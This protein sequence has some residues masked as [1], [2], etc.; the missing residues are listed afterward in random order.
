VSAATISEISSYQYVFDMQLSHDDSVSWM[1]MGLDPLSDMF[2][3]RSS[4]LNQMCT[5]S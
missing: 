4:R 3:M 2:V 1:P 5:R